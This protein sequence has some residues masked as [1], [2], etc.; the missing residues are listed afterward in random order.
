MIRVKCYLK[1]LSS[2]QCEAFSI[3]Y[4]LA[5]QA[6]SVAEVT[7]KLRKIIYD[8]IN[9]GEL[10][11]RVAPMSTRLKYTFYKWW[12]ELSDNCHVYTEYVDEI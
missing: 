9:D 7:E 10:M 3:E 11:D 8:Y 4:G 5:A 12:G 6:D 1:I 2:G